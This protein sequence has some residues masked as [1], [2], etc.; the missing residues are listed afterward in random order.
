MP[1]QQREPGEQAGPAGHG[2]QP[3][4]VQG[5]RLRQPVRHAA[6]GHEDEAEAVEKVRFD[7]LGRA[8]AVGFAGGRVAAAHVHGRQQPRT[9]SQGPSPEEAIQH[10]A[11]QLPEEFAVSQ[12]SGLCYSYAPR[13]RAV[14]SLPLSLFGPTRPLDWPDSAVEFARSAALVSIGFPFEHVRAFD[15]VEK[16]AGPLGKYNLPFRTDNEKHSTA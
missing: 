11:K 9:T 7:G 16:F 12:V 1:E 13:G 10:H 14:G 5:R 6:T 8:V 2:G 3:D 4:V 15:R